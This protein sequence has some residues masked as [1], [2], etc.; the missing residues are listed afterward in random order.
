VATHV[1]LLRGVNVGGHHQVPMSGLRKVFEDLGHTDV[2]T[3]IQ[4]GNVLFTAAGKVDPAGLESAIEAAFGI[5]VDVVVRTP[6][7]LR[8]AL[9]ADPFPGAA[10]SA[11]HVGFMTR[12]PRPAEVAG[13]DAERYRPEEFAVVGSDLYLH[14]PNG[15][16]RA[17]LPPYL[18]R[19]LPP[20]T[21]RNWKTVTKLAD[22][23]GD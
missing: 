6:K 1:A 2:S 13:I 4:S 7:E 3:Y 8:R 19:H 9:L 17:K 5:D 20:T 23:A 10:R 22:L 21:V 15:M 16:G 14:L 12:R 18:G 11:V